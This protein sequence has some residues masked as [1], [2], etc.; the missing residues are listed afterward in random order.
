[1]ALVTKTYYG[2][3]HEFSLQ[4]GQGELPVQ[5]LAV[6]AAANGELRRGALGFYGF[7]LLSKVQAWFYQKQDKRK[8]GGRSRRFG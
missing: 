6:D 8:S 4:S 2:H 1:M 3:A 5:T 7:I